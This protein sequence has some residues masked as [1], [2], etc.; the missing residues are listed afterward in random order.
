M[1]RETLD[2]K[3]HFC[4]LVLTRP[5]RDMLDRPHFRRQAACYEVAEKLQKAIRQAEIAIG[6][7]VDRASN[8]LR[9]RF[10]SN[11]FEKF[12]DRVLDASKGMRCIQQFGEVVPKIRDG[13]DGFR[14]RTPRE[15]LRYARNKWNRLICSTTGTDPARFFTAHS[16]VPCKQA[17][18]SP[19]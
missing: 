7:D 18:V 8:D 11:D 2:Q 13:K 19:K 17:P 4:G 12:V 14:T 5:M 3:E 10:F 9:R 16:S 6:F 1:S 15:L